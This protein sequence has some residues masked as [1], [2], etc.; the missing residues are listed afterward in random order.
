M[1]DA[2]WLARSDWAAGRI[3]AKGGTAVAVPVLAVLV[4]WWAIA[5]LPL[6]RKLPEIFESASSTW[7]VITLI[8]PAMGT[9]LLLAFMYQVIRGLKFGQSVLELESIPGVVGGQLA[10]GVH[11]PRRV[12]PAG[13]FQLSLSCIE[14]GDAE[15][16]LWR[17]ERRVTV[18][19]RD[20]RDGGIIVPVRFAI[21]YEAEE[22]V[23]DA[24][25]REIQW[26]LDVLAEM[27]GVDYK[28]RF[29]V[30]VFKTPHSRPDFKLDE[31][32][33]AKSE[34]G[35]RRDALL[36]EAGI[37]KEPLP[38]AGVRLVFTA[39][40]HY[41]AALSFTVI[42]LMW[43]GA[44]WLMLRAGSWVVMPILF[45]LID[46]LLIWLTAGL[47]LYRSVVEARPDGLMLQGGFFGIG[48]KNFIR[49][50]E[51]KE[52]TTSNA[53]SVNNIVW[54]N[55][56]A[57]LGDEKERTIARSIE[58]KLGQQAVI[59]ELNSALRRKDEQAAENA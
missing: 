36:R 19:T 34:A 9:A 54:Y 47:W 32:L 25:G 44:I 16:P 12:C 33:A 3:R 20:Q 38:G 55:I 6:M 39:G 1:A 37:L 15:R 46:L 35:P 22:T 52:I 17:K 56:A 48:R 51:V 45:G 14:D 49:A 4:V 11:I 21:P 7:A 58:G 57:V 2:P 24:S 27:P 40:R 10:G 5:S 50:D 53:M 26:R 31:R 42:T 13:G 43:S 30:P 59:A 28:A 8:F 41:D 23:R 29:E 18:P